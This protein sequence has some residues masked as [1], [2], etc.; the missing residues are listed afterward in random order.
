MFVTLPLPT[1]NADPNEAL[2]Q[3]VEACQGYSNADID[4]AVKQFLSGLVKGQNPDF[5]PTPARFAQQ[6]R[7]NLDYR[8]TSIQSQKR[9]VQQFREQEID[10][11]W[12]GR[13][14]PESQERVKSALDQ[15]KANDKERT[16]E[17]IVEA[18]EQ[19]RKSDVLFAD[20]FVEV[21]GLKVSQSLITQ[22]MSERNN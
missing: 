20:Q 22:L 10:E 15:F 16:P 21:D 11:Q 14:T 17:E 5:A 9:L 3:Y 7:A 19:L 6:L 1:A 12:A 2:R 18:K 13:R 4:L 8:A